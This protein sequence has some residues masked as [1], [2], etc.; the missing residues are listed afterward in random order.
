MLGK[1]NEAL[2]ISHMGLSDSEDLVIDPG[3][4]SQ[5]DSPRPPLQEPFNPPRADLFPPTSVHQP[6]IIDQDVED[7]TT[8]LDLL[9]A[10]FRNESVREFLTVKRAILHEQI[11]TIEG[12]RKRCNA[13][14]AL[15]QDE[16]E[17]MK[18]QLAITTSAMT[19][20]DLHRNALAGLLGSLKLKSAGLL[21]KSQVFSAWQKHHLSCHEKSRLSCVSTKLGLK[22]ISR[23]IF[24]AWK[25]HWAD[26]HQDKLREK[27]AFLLQ[28]E[29]KAL[30]V[31]YG[32]EIQLLQDRLDSA[33]KELEQ[34][35]KM[36]AVMQEN[37]KKAF[38]RGVC[39]LNFEAMNILQ[40][41]QGGVV[42]QDF[43]P[44]VEA[45]IDSAMMEASARPP[46]QSSSTPPSQPVYAPPSQA[47]YAPPPPTEPDDVQN[48]PPAESKDDRWKPAP[49]FGARPM[50][51]P[52]SKEVCPSHPSETEL[53]SV[54][55]SEA[56]L[57]SLP[58]N[59]NK[60]QG[61]GKTIVVGRNLEGEVKIKTKTA[62][63]LKAKKAGSKK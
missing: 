28:E 52:P 61:Q 57:S 39:A 7:F 49:V 15:K 6:H 20:Y 59:L 21:C 34:E 38:M 2:R 19:N 9:V 13:Q 58:C 40:P 30:N 48:I 17:H 16:L 53:E 14:L 25:S 37:L 10:Q 22:C 27:E 26:Y 33:L 36:K 4:S 18:E 47:M 12:E 50:T 35:T 29:R 32:K 11:S 31:Q 45:V 63:A 51:A 24:S 5:P 46:P 42:S 1:R 55:E 56:T 23:R 41:G 62:V 60:P 54:V 8:K 3:Q 44:G 43:F